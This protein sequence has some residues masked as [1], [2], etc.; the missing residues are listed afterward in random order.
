MRGG[1]PSSLRRGSVCKRCVDD[2]SYTTAFA[3]YKQHIR[4]AKDAADRAL[5]QDLTARNL[6]GA[7]FKLA[8]AKLHPTPLIPPLET[9]PDVVTSLVLESASLLLREHV[10]TYDSSSDTPFHMRLR[11]LARCAYPPVAND[12]AFT[13]PEIEHALSQALYL[14]K[15]RLLSLKASKTPAIVISLDFTGA[16]DSVRHAAVLFFLRRHR[17]PAKLY[18]LLHSFLMDRWV[19]FRAPAG[20]VSARPRIGSPQGSPIS[21]LLWNMPASLA[22]FAA[23]HSARREMWLKVIIIKTSPHAQDAEIDARKGLTAADSSATTRSLSYNPENTHA[24]AEQSSPGLPA[25]VPAPLGA[26]ESSLEMTYCVE[27]ENITPEELESHPRWERA[28]QARKPVYPKIKHAES[29]ALPAPP[30]G[31]TGSAYS[32]TTLATAP[33]ASR[34][35]KMHAPLPKLPKTC[36]G[37]V[38]LPLVCAATRI[39]YNTAQQQDKLRL[40]PFN[41]SFTLS[42]PAEVRS[43]RYVSVNSLQLGTV[44][45]PLREYVAAPDDAEQEIIQDLQ[46]MNKSSQYTITDARPLGKTKSILIPFII[47]QALPKQLNFYRTLYACHPFKAKVEA[48]HHCCRAGHRVDVCAHPKSNLC[49]CILCGEAHLTGSKKCKVRFDRPGNNSPT[50]AGKVA[51]VTEKRVNPDSTHR[52]SSRSRTRLPSDPPQ[53][54]AR[55]SRSR[56]EYRTRSG[57]T[58][59]CGWTRS[60]STSYPHLPGTE[61]ESMKQVSWGPRSPSH[62]RENKELRAQLQKQSAEIAELR[63]QIQLLLKRDMHT[64][65]TD[66][67]NPAPPAT[68]PSV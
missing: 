22:E 48:C 24:T 55:A 3:A 46:A 66:S 32:S 65:R 61:T 43:K 67:P 1:T 64:R 40:N 47:V 9:S 15:P 68:A 6:D 62:E 63:E 14:L 30:A 17:Y 2:F 60:R 45:Y 18:H 54:P 21:S 26:I 25:S 31:S 51:L 53:K 57:F 38:L 37:G 59:G 35:P 16:F 42:T 12:H 5:C 19:V 10:A 23:V 34:K 50:A 52:R 7:P 8:F 58:T 44:K 36:N 13:L 49:P 33:L 27:G 29:T 39:D 56:T 11:A 20:E 41:S 4:S 28:F